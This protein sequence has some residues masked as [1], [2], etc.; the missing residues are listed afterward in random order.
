[1]KKTSV[2][3][4]VVA[5]FAA[6]T[7]F[8]CT[9]DVTDS[10]PV[11]TES[12]ASVTK[13]L[14]KYRTYEEALAVAQDAIGLL[15]ESST[16]RSGKPRTVNT[17]D[18]QYILNSSATRSDD[19]PDTLMYVFNYEDNAGFAVVSANR[20]TEELIAVT[21]QGNYVAGEET[22]NGGFDLY[23]DLAEEYVLTAAESFPSIGGGDDDEQEVLTE[24]KMFVDR[25]TA[26][27]G[28]LVSVRWGQDW[29][30]NMSCPK[31]DG[32]PSKAGCVATA[33]AQ[34][35]SYYK[36]PS[37]IIAY[38]TYGMYEQVLDWDSINQHV[39]TEDSTS[40]N[41]SQCVNNEWHNVIGILIERIG[42][43]VNMWYDY[44]TSIA[45]SENVASA[46]ADFGY[47]SD[48]YQS[49]NSTV[50]TNSIRSKKL[51]Y[52]CGA[53]LNAS[54]GHA[55]IVDGYRHIHALHRE[56]IRPMPQL[57][58]TELR[59]WTTDHYYYHINWGWNGDSNGYFFRDVFNTDS[60]SDLDT[61]EYEESFD[62]TTALM[63]YANI[64]KK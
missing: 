16:T 3:K 24:Y 36:H 21:E 63:M 30:Y 17:S 42:R 14:P 62:F 34:I 60:S 51:V 46:F 1:M 35:F 58:W 23:M 49:Y 41:C 38:D 57:L 50:V 5:A 47:S 25:D 40:T 26:T 13:E 43:E 20:A 19:E 48:S 4:S 56:C 55:W 45:F 37:S 52:M 29:P 39:Y 8:A 54:I 10:L 27:L 6:S 32:L 7:L 15:G 9:Q 12:D 59:R 2:L 44:E 33:L 11:Q 64:T 22:G 31:T 18:V 28:P 61:E 53:T